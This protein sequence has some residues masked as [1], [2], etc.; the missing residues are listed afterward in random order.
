MYYLGSLRISQRGIAVCSICHTSVRMESFLREDVCVVVLW[1]MFHG[2]PTRKGGVF[3]MGESCCS[4]IVI[5]LGEKSHL[6]LFSQSLC[7]RVMCSQP[8]L[9]GLLW[10]HLLRLL[11]GEM[12]WS[13]APE[14][15]ALLYSYLL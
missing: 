11:A 14:P 5:L 3:S 12:A 2:T 6:C 15:E 7:R 1:L 10:P 8:L 4:I 13:L 9:R